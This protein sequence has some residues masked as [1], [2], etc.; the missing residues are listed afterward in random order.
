M[1]GD[2]YDFARFVAENHNSY[3]CVR[4]FSRANIG[5]FITMT[6]KLMSTN[7]QP[8][9]FESSS[10]LAKHEVHLF[11]KQRKLKALRE[12]IDTNGE[13]ESTRQYL[14]IVNSVINKDKHNSR[15]KIIQ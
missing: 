5:K 13:I 12:K 10:S 2:Y 1:I 11:I 6:N 7:I 15:V 4:G 8:I 9:R 3:I 14:T